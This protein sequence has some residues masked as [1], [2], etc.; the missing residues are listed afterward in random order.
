MMRPLVGQPAELMLDVGPMLQTQN[1]VPIVWNAAEVVL[2]D[3]Q[4]LTVRWE[5]QIEDVMGD[6]CH[7]FLSVRQKFRCCQ[8]RRNDGPLLPHAA[9]SQP[10]VGTIRHLYILKHP[11]A[12]CNKLIQRE[13]DWQMVRPS[14]PVGAA[15]W[16]RRSEA[17]KSP[18]LQLDGDTE[19][20]RKG[21]A[22]NEPNILLM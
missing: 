5:V 12:K 8:A 20:L 21:N 16:S 15:R 19:P 1:P 22:C 2:S 3:V 17:T 6:S 18:L 14:W 13:R 4:F 7:R 9:S 11:E 10:A